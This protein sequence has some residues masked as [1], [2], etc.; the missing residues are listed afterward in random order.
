M[1]FCKSFVNPPR[2]FILDKELKNYNYLSDVS[3]SFN[4]LKTSLLSKHI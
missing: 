3:Y 2:V 1:S 4:F